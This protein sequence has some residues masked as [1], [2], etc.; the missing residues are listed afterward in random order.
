ME[1]TEKQKEWKAN[2]YENNKEGYKQKQQERR[3]SIKE[4]IDSCK[5]KCIACGET[6]IAC[7]DF[8]H[9]DK[10]EKEV[11]IPTA[12]KN[13]WGEERILKEINKCVVLCSNCHRKLHYYNLS[14]NE[15]NK[16]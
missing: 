4:F 15:L 6:D 3:K 13:K 1:Q 2:H 7:L 16:I 11:T 14:I 5:T 12:I 8:H 9:I 10:N